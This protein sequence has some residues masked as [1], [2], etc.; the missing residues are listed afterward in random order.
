MIEQIINLSCKS[1]KNYTTPPNFFDKKNILF[2]YNGMGKSS[3]ALG[4]VNSYKSK[5]GTENSYRLFNR[6]YVKNNL[7]LNDDISLIKGV[8]VTF[9]KN[10]AEIAKKIQELEQEKINIETLTSNIDEENR[11]LRNK[12]DNIHNQ[13]KGKAKINKKRGDLPNAD[14][15]DAY[16]A[17]L[18]RA[19]TINPSD[20]QIKSFIPD[21]V[22]LEKKKSIIENLKIPNLAIKKISNEDK[23]F[24]TKILKKSYNFGD[25][26][27]SQEEMKW[28]DD[29]INLHGDSDK[30]CKFCQSCFNIYDV[31]NRVKEYKENEKQK[32]IKHLFD[33][34]NIIKENL[35]LIEQQRTFSKSLSQIGIDPEI[36]DKIYNSDFMLEVREL[37]DTIGNK[38]E[39]MS[40]MFDTTNCITTF[41]DKIEQIHEEITEAHKK[42][43]KDI[44]NTSNNIET[45]AKGKIA[46]ALQDSDIQKDL[47]KIRKLEREIL[48]AS[49]DN[50]KIDKKIRE[51]K[52]GQSEY[53]DFMNYLNDVLESLGV[54]IK[55]ILS[56]KNYYLKHS[57][58]ESELTINDISEGEKN[59]LSLLYFYF[60][61]YTDKQQKILNEDIELIVVDDPISSLDD[62]NKFYVLEII[63]NMLDTSE[64]QIFVLT[65]SWDDFCQITYNYKRNTPSV[66]LFE[67]YK[68][69]TKNFQSEIRGCHKN[70]SPYK[71]LFSELYELSNKNLNDLNDCDVYHAANSMRRVFEEFLIFKSS[72]LLP[73]RSSQNRILEIYKNATGRQ[74]SKKDSLKLGSFLT[75]INVLS[76]RSIKSAEILDNCK[77]LLKIIKEMDKVHY[78][79]MKC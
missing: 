2:G 44:D 68:D 1:F 59:L 61:L 35:S 76:H 29:G 7:L 43:I 9:S 54:H 77:F 55:L 63:K 60:E 8:K 75:F 78:D 24:L 32:D 38:I 6:D 65:H 3:L 33:I 53:I 28:L 23:E 42:T 69:S 56:E 41:E 25:D 14:V 26:I 18:E 30:K 22:E 49:E 37:V 16:K 19:H 58:E 27:P 51:L 10:D 40:Y 71:K 45:L 39:N 17:D 52:E 66:K 11:I 12:I 36:M 79:S 15:I 62:A 31:I 73:Q 48:K 20:E 34:K 13:N 74:M 4:I 70:I 64:P 46:L 72:N 21:N 67:I 50:K 57:I 47:S 5:G